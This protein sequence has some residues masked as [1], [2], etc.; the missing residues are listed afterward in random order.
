[1]CV[2]TQGIGSVFIVIF[3]LNQVCVA[4]YMDWFYHVLFMLSYLSF[5]F[6]LETDVI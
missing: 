4:V 3:C 6:L 5:F 1:M 2:Y